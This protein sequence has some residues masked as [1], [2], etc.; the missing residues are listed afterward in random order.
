MERHQE[1]EHVRP[2]YAYIVMNVYQVLLDAYEIY[3]L[4][5]VVHVRVSN[6]F[7]VFFLL[8]TMNRASKVFG[9]DM[10]KP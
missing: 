5:T 8:Q 9:A 4:Y 10:E 3:I 6:Y 1:T 2:M 7:F